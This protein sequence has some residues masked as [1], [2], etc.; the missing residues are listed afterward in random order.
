MFFAAS[1]AASKEFDAKRDIREVVGSSL[2][3]LDDSLVVFVPF[4]R[5]DYGSV[6]LELDPL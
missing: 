2:F 1:W 3:L 5:H 6:G 4:D